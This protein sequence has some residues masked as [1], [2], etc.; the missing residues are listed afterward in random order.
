MSMKALVAFLKDD[1]NPPTAMEIKAFKES[2]T[3]DQWEAFCKE[4]DAIME[5][6]GNPHL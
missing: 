6:R 2:C 5:E 4:A 3:P 1:P